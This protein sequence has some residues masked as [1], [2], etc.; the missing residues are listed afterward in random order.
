MLGSWDTGRDTA[1]YSITYEYDESNRPK[2]RR[3]L[4]GVNYYY[5]IDYEY[6]ALNRL[7][8]INSETIRAYMPGYDLMG[9]KLKLTYSPAGNYATSWFITAYDST[10]YTY[11]LY[12]SIRYELNAA[13]QLVREVK[14]AQ[15][16]GVNSYV[17]DSTVYVY[18]GENLTQTREY[19]TAI[20]NPQAFITTYE[21]DTGPNP[22]FGLSGD[23]V[24]RPELY[25]S[26]N[27]KTKRIDQWIFYHSGQIIST[28]VRT[29]VN[30]YDARG[31][32]S[33]VSSRDNFDS[34]KES[35][36]YEDY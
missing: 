2:L 7:T 18:T 20:A 17:R 1:H 27:N 21:Y 19:Q 31:R 26:K 23:L 36:H 16:T 24:D 3:R 5:I 6:D 35:Y 22:Y 13:H 9:Y 12:D 15:F 14:Y 28:S 33:Q 10:G 4:S 11:S 30:S 8:L 32:L 34:A 29:Y 25:H